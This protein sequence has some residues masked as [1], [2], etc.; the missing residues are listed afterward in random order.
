MGAALVVTVTLD[1]GRSEPAAL[2]HHTIRTRVFDRSTGARQPG[3]S[4][5]LADITRG[6]GLIRLGPSKGL[7]RTTPGY[8]RGLL[9]LSEIRVAPTNAVPIPTANMTTT[10]ISNQ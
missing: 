7:Q 8:F 6:Q 2:P 9:L 4:A 10:T 3:N 5:A 1:V